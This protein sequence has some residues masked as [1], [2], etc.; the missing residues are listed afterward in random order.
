M[1]YSGGDKDL[2][3]YDKVGI[4]PDVKVA[5][6]KAPEEV[7]IHIVPQSED[8]QLLAAVELFK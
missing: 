8:A 6:D 4:E 7:N 3:G 2:V 5:L 1:Y